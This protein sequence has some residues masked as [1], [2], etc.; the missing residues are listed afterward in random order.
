MVHTLAM[1]ITAFLLNKTEAKEDTEIYVYGIELMISGLLGVVLVILAG[2][3]IN[4]PVYSIIFLAVIIPV[5]MYTGGYHSDSFIVCNIVFVASF[6][7][8]VYMSN[9]CYNSYYSRL[10][11]ILNVIA[12]FV[13]CGFAPLENHNKQLTDEQK[14]RY[15]TISIVLYILLMS[16]SVCLDITGRILYMGNI[17]IYSKISLYINIIQIIIA[18]LLLIGVGKERLSHEKVL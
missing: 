15:K 13:I 17:N 5:R 3:I 18:I 4:E 12:L 9:L 1:G 10:I 14:S 7:C 16:F 8:S 2:F 11:W 6:I